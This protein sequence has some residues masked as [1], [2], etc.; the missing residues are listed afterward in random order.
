MLKKVLKKL[1][2]YCGPWSLLRYLSRQKNGAGI[3]ILYGHRVL[4]DSIINDKHDP[5]TVTGHTS[6]SQV[7]EA[8]KQ[9]R[10]RYNI[11]SIEE[12]YFQL[13]Q[14]EVTGESVVLT[15]DDGFRDNFKYLYPTLKKCSVPATLYINPSVIDTEVNLWFQSIINYFYAI[16]NDRHYISLNNTEYD[17]STPSKRYQAA[18]NFMQ[19]IQANKKPQEFIELIEQIAGELS[20]PCEEDFHMSWKELEILAADPLITIGAH[21]QNHFPLG[22]CDEK[23]STSEILQSINELESKLEIKIKHF[24]YPRGHVEDFNQFHIDLLKS[25]GISSAVSTIRGVN[26]VGADIFRLKRIGFPQNISDDLEEFM[27]HVGGIPQ[28]LQKFKNDKKNH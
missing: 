22:Y 6:V 10:K 5:R 23:L 12:A 27:W 26:Y 9:L 28:M 18:F 19:F 7:E 24:G 25:L 11:I 16:P 17:L 14:G 4:P 8:I 13:K 2:L 20:R 15:F 21:T 3:S 1:F